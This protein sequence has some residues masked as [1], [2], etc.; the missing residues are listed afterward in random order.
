LG[1]PEDIGFTEVL[2]WYALAGHSL[3]AMYE[4]T[5]VYK[6]GKGGQTSFARALLEDVR[7]DRLFST[8]VAEISQTGGRVDI[9]T[10]DG[11]TISARSVVC[12]IP[13]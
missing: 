3:A 5:S 11:K 9:R 4:Q 6:L 7:A 8:A 1:K 13:L 2:R 10:T 12:T